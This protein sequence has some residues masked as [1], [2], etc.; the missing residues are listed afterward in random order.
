[1]HDHVCGSGNVCDKNSAT[2]NTGE[3]ENALTSLAI[4]VVETLRELARHTKS[5]PAFVGV[6]EC[7]NCRTA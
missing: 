1:M 4:D 3:E 2:I 6:Y 5:A 7:V